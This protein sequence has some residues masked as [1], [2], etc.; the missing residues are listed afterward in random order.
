MARDS[1]F[2][3]FRIFILAHEAHAARSAAFVNLNRKLLV[4]DIFSDRAQL[5]AVS[6]PYYRIQLV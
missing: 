2:D 3:M 5:E 6:T 1:S 4:L